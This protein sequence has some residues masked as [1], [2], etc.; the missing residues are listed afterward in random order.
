[1]RFVKE[2]H[3][4]GLFVHLRIGPYA[5]AEWN[6]GLVLYSVFLIC[7]QFPLLSLKVINACLGGFLNYCLKFN[8]QVDNKM[9]HLQYRNSLN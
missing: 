3:E 9:N 8:Y 4:A 2:V 1:M 6:Y 7:T 5:C